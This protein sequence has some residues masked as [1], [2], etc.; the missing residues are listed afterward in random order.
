MNHQK[1][2]IAYTHSNSEKKVHS[3]ILNLGIESYLPLHKVKK[4]WSDRTKVMELPLFS[5][6]LFVKTTED[7]IPKLMGI[8]GI[9]RFLSFEKKLAT[10]KERE[11]ELIKKIIKDGKDINAEKGTFSNGQRVRITGGNY[12]GCHRLKFG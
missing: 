3:R 7:K 1:R 2:F 6:Y 4:K 5:S 9:A 10:I 12:S 11:I 8:E